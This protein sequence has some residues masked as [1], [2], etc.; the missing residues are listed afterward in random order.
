[1][2]H[3]PNIVLPVWTGLELKEEGMAVWQRRGT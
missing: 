1:M 2:T 3:M